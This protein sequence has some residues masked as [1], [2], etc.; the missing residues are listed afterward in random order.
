MSNVF[1][2]Q[3]E[4]MKEA[5]VMANLQHR[6]IVRLIGVCKSDTIM[7]VMELAPLGQLNKY[8]KKHL[9]V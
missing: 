1:V 6:N 5:R 7:L 4:L 8:L 2:F 3:S 9:W